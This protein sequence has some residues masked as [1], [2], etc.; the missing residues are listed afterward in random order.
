METLMH[1]HG[2][3]LDA[4]EREY[5]IPKNEIS[6]FSGNINPFG[7]PKKAAEKL[8]QNIS[9]VCNYPDKNYI[10]LKNSISLYTG[11]KPENIVVGN[12][13]TELISTFIKSVC[14][15]KTIIMGPAYSE[16][17][18]AV[19]LAG[20]DFEYFEL[21]EDENFVPNIDRLISVLKDEVG[22]FIACNPNNPTGTAIA[23]TDMR[24]LLTHCKKNNISVMIDETYIEFSNNLE[25]I[26]SIP[27]VDEFDNIFVIRGTS[28]FF[29]APGLR[30]GYGITSSAEFHKLL[31]ENQDP[32][33]VN[34]LA[35]Y[36][37]ELIFSDIDFIKETKHLISSERQK[38]YDELLTWKN[39]K[40]YKSSSNFLLAKLL[41]DKITAAEIFDQMVRKKMVI[42]DAASFTY[43]NEKYIRF[44]IL[45]PEENNRLL[46]ELK[47]IIE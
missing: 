23:I 2:G 44:C 19:K 38:I 33:S 40:V 29:A 9:I 26:C 31:A 20:S 35:A 39:I 7:F 43:L 8:A 45:S 42:R 5:G 11:A 46:S 16:Y 32:W 12:G 4:I 41:T 1:M 14:A 24:K 36:A 18:N 13:S 6:D 37:G 30:L 22:L 3:D 34:I 25:E 15:K 47:N 27:L 10:A 17:E 28:K 21:R